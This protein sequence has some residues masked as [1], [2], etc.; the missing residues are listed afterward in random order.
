MAIKIGGTTVIDDVRSLTNIQNA[1]LNSYG[2]IRGLFETGNVTATAPGANVQMDLATQT[3]QYFT[4]NATTN[5]TVN[6]RGNSTASLDSIMNTGNTVSAAIM[7]TNGATPYRPTVYQIDGTAV[8]SNIKWQN[9]TAP[10]S[11]NASSVDIYTITITKTG[12]A[13]F[14]VFGSQTKFA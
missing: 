11:G 12:S 5:T 3:V 6:F 7:I 1:T 8:T 13:A 10:S 2:S 4:S 9:G 14:T